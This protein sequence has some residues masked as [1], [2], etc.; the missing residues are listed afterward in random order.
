MLSWGRRDTTAAEVPGPA[1]S[2]SR[3][4][5]S[6]DPKI[7]R[8][9]AHVAQVPVFFVGAQARRWSSAIKIALVLDIAILF[10]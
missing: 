3:F 7:E 9:L 4:Y 2:T 5:G 8:A 6:I 1:D 10:A